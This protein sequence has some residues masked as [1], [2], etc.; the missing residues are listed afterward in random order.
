MDENSVGVEIVGNDKDAT[1]LQIVIVDYLRAIGL[2]IPG[3]K[4]LDTEVRLHREWLA[5][6]APTLQVGVTV[7]E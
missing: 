7:P 5:K 6:S 3:R 2:S 1:S 4:Y